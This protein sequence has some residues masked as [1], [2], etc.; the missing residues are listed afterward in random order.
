MSNP[1]LISNI[2]E[3]AR[4][5]WED[6]R[7]DVT[8]LGTRHVA[9]MSQCTFADGAARYTMA[10]EQVGRMIRD[11]LRTRYEKAQAVQGRLVKD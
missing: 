10:W 8:V 7:L 1:I 11:D 5:S 2:L 3:R 4:I 6:D 9:D